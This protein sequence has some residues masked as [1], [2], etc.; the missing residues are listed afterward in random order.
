MTIAA[1]LLGRNCWAVEND[2]LQMLSMRQRVR[3]MQRA[4]V[5][6][7]VWSFCDDLSFPKHGQAGSEGSYVRLQAERKHKNELIYQEYYGHRL[8]QTR[9]YYGIPIQEPEEGVGKKPIDEDGGTEEQKGDGWEKAGD[10]DGEGR[11]QANMGNYL[12]PIAGGD[13]PDGSGSSS[14]ST[15][16]PSGVAVPPAGDLLLKSANKSP[17]GN[18]P[19]KNKGPSARDVKT[20]AAKKKKEDK[21]AAK[22]KLQA[23]EK[24]EK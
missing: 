14:T 21:A 10:V 5:D 13:Q 1:G 24:E 4:L 17:T 20:A 3:E 19:T 12:Q 23:K 18:P 11:R 22:A 16:L 15:G 6:P 7:K 9:H 8:A 2:S